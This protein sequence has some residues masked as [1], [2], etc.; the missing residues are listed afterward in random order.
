M[1]PNP[2]RKPKFPAQQLK[3]PVKRKNPSFDLPQSA[4]GPR[5][6]SCACCRRLPPWPS[7]APPQHCLAPLPFSLHHRPATGRNVAAALPTDSSS[8]SRSA[9][10][11]TPMTPLLPPQPPGHA[12]HAPSPVAA[13]GPSW[14]GSADWQA[15]SPRT[16]ARGRNHQKLV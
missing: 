13:A 12:D 11:T 14:I 16:A 4:E 5:R 6:L 10:P 2:I 3:Y 1:Q 7:L 15:W 8:R 9:M